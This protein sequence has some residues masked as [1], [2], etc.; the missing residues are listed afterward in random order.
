MTRIAKSLVTASVI[1]LGAAAPAF[2]KTFIYCSEASP[3]G[4]DPAPYTAGS[5]FDASAHPVYN[6]LLEFTK[7]TTQVEPGLAES[8]EVSDDGLEVTFHLRKGVKWQSNDAFTPTREF[9][10]DDVIFSYERQASADHPWHLYLPG[11]TYEYFSAMEMSSLIS[12][13][14]KIDDHTVKFVLSRPEA[15][16]L[17]NIAMPFASIVSAE[18][19]ETLAAAGHMEDLNNAPIGTGPFSFVAYQKDAVI[20]YKKNADY[21]GPAPAIDDLVFA[22]T[23]DA[24]VRLQK[25]KAGECHLM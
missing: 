8:W 17:A 6:R 9:N 13:I 25:L 14:E 21:W 22:I 4:F 7:G 19:A 10:A 15:P 23:P 12:T 20:R 16:F 3:E 11:I 2:A 1:A 24:S 5:T 18:Y